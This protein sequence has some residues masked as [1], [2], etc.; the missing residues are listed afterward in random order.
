MTA[1]S[2]MGVIELLGVPFPPL[3]IEGVDSAA[4]KIPLGS[5]IVGLRKWQGFL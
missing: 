5:D 3:E 2:Y 4:K 1:S